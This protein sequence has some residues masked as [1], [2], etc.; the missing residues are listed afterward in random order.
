MLII[1]CVL[2][3][4]PIMSLPNN[5]NFPASDI[6]KYKEQLIAAM[7][8][9]GATKEDF[10]AFDDELLQDMVITAMFNKQKPEDVA[11]ALL[12]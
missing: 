2:K 8:E 3:G 9:Q 1:K 12:Q 5:V 11:W 10:E 4:G 7:K 6:A